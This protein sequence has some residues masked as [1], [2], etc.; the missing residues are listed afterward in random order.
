MKIYRIKDFQHTYRALEEY[1]YNENT[2]LIKMFVI[3][4]KSNYF[5][6]KKVF[7]NS[8][9]EEIQKYVLDSNDLYKGLLLRGDEV[10]EVENSDDD[11]DLINYLGLWN[12]TSEIK[13][14]KVLIDGEAYKKEN[15]EDLNAKEEDTEPEADL[16]I[17]SDN[18]LNQSGF[19]R[20]VEDPFESLSSISSIPAQIK[21]QDVVDK[22]PEILNKISLLLTNIDSKMDMLLKNKNNNKER[23][24]TLD[25][26]KSDKLVADTK[27]KECLFEKDFDRFQGVI[28]N[29]INVD[30][31]G[32]NIFVGDLVNVC[33]EIYTADNNLNGYESKYITK[34]IDYKIRTNYNDDYDDYY[35][36]KLTDEEIKK[37][38]G[39]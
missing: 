19:Y 22:T 12:V 33:E 10:Y 26:V 3:P 5:L 28:G 27:Y 39:K 35:T 4:E 31:Y 24:I 1:G 18:T 25:M 7:D 38:E 16:K 8:T 11:S 32:N 20:K 9:K 17:K 23:T 21:S 30:K 15:S 37:Y 2:E 34:L 29:K 13:D 6:K 36:K 14:D